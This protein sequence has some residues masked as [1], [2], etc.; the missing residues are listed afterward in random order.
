[1]NRE[2]WFEP[3][4]VLVGINWPVLS[5]CMA[6]ACAIDQLTPSDPLICERGSVTDLC[7]VTVHRPE[8][9][10]VL[11]TPLSAFCIVAGAQTWSASKLNVACAGSMRGAVQC[12]HMRSL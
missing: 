3:Q 5:G 12:A 7:E 6:D 9:L 2:A 1:M 11:P 10:Q 8:G 4:H